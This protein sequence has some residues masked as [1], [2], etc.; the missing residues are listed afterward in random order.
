MVSQ[1]HLDVKTPCQYGVINYSEEK[2]AFYG[3]LD[4]S[5]SIDAD[6]YTGSI[7]LLIT[8]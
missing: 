6:E 5:S 2:G 8:Y 7:N 4:I 3:Y 1:K